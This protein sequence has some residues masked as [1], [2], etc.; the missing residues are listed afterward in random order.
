MAIVMLKA[1]EM[2]C[3]HLWGTTQGRTPYETVRAIC[4]KCGMM[5]HL[6]ASDGTVGIDTS[7]RVRQYH[8]T[9]RL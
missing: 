6:I 2:A 5:P 3:N 8:G 7:E 4:L 9:K 1:E